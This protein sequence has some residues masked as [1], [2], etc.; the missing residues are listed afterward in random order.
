MCYLSLT[1]ATLSNLILH[2]DT[3]STI[4]QKQFEYSKLFGIPKVA[5]YTLDA[6]QKGYL[7]ALNAEIAKRDEFLPEVTIK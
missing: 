3:D 2:Q 6:L 4:H 7:N 5:S 1:D